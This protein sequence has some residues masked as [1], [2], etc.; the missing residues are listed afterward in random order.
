MNKILMHAKIDKLANRI[1]DLDLGDDR[2]A[3]IN[4]LKLAI[5]SGMSLAVEQMMSKVRE[6]TRG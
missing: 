6:V 3:Q 1:Q 5:S 2:D 4:R